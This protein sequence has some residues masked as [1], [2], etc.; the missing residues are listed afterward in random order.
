M[1]VLFITGTDTDVGKT[2][3]TVLISDCL[4]EHGRHFVPFKPVQTGAV[5]QEGKWFAPDI[6]TYG[7]SLDDELQPANYL[8]KTP[9]SPHLAASL[10]E[11]T[12]EPKRLT[13]SVGQ[14]ERTYDGVV[15]EGAGGL[16]VP[17]TIDGFC[18]IDW[19]EELKAPVILVTRTGVGTI[20]HTL[21]SIEAMKS[22]GIPIAG[23]LFNELVPQETG[24]TEDNMRMIALL[25]DVPVIG[26]IPYQDDIHDTLTDP[27]KRKACYKQWNYKIVQEA[28]QDGN[29]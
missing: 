2:V 7:L 4:R 14:L 16:Y 18:L 10:E 13:Q 12:I 28:L 1:S 9:C 3:A 21:L 5:L 24:I 23:L 22:R 6:L 26:I 19:M 8:L 27:V 25:S 15:V 11:M 20:N 17:L 29:K